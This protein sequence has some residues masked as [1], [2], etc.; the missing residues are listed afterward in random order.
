LP[1][2]LSIPFF[3]GSSSTEKRGGRFAPARTDIDPLDFS[4]ALADMALADVIEESPLRFRYRV[5]GDNLIS[6]DG[7]NMRGKCLEDIPEP[8]YRERV[9]AAWTRV[10]EQR[11]PVHHILTAIV[12][13]RPRSYESLVLPLSADGVRVTMIIGIQRHR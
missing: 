5:V 6:R 8:E 4:Y 12:D 7:Y 2:P 10:V 13:K 3:A 1:Q 11:Q 9:R